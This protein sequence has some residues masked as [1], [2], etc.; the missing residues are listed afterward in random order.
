MYDSVI[1]TL[2]SN[3]H[4]GN[5]SH[6]LESECDGLGLNWALL[7]PAGWLQKGF[8]SS[9]GL[10]TKRRQSRLPKRAAAASLSIISSLLFTS[11][12][13]GVVFTWIVPGSLEAASPSLAACKLEPCVCVW[14]AVCQVGRTLRLRAGHRAW[15][16]ARCRFRVEMAT[17]KGTGV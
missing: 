12:S 16:T 8:P 11:A 1:E 17:R 10:R 2:E 14:P 3:D 6:L 5:T 13:S 9:V 4:S 7:L 15:L